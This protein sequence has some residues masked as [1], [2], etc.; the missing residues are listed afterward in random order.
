MDDA[1]IDAH[2]RQI[3]INYVNSQ[4]EYDMGTTQE[5]MLA[6]RAPGVA[7]RDVRSRTDFTF[8]T[9][10]K[11]RRHC[12]GGRCPDGNA[13]APG[14]ARA[15]QESVGTVRC[16]WRGGPVGG[17]SGAFSG[18]AGEG[19]VCATGLVDEEYVANPRVSW[20]GH[21]PRPPSLVC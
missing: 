19:R 15:L 5:I 8:L 2:G 3:S 21:L 14:M 6:R 18:R 12:L 7:A 17:R 20:G 4:N 1:Q 11:L 10:F 13:S 9:D 16:V